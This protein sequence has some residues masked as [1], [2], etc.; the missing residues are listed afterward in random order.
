MFFVKWLGCEIF[1]S[2]ILT[3]P[4]IETFSQAI[5]NGKP[6]PN[7][8]LAFGVIDRGEDWV[9]ATAVHALGAGGTRH[10]YLCRFYDVGALSVRVRLSELKINDDWHPSLT[11]RFVIADLVGA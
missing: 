2:N 11:N 9:G 3:E 5:M 8:W 10:D 4:G 7:L 1:E 6:H